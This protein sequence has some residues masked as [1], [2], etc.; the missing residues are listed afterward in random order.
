M[1]R[2]RRTNEFGELLKEMDGV[3]LKTLISE[4]NAALNDY[5]KKHSKARKM[6][7]AV[8]MRDQTKIGR[9]AYIL[10]KKEI[11]TGPV[12]AISAEKIKIRL[13][14]GK[15]KPYHILKLIEAQKAKEMIIEGKATM[16]TFTSSEGDPA[17]ETENDSVDVEDIDEAQ[18]AAE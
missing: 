4:A 13:S 16:A 7:E 12:T 3:K 10:N 11:I 8:M 1:A 2:G 18:E 14:N 15:E 9:T 17:E 5:D 6:D